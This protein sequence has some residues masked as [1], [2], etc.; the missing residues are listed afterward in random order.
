[1]FKGNCQISRRN[2]SPAEVKTFIEEGVTLCVNP[3]IKSHLENYD[4]IELT[5]PEQT[6]VV[7]LGVGDSLIVTDPLTHLT[8]ESVSVAEIISA[9]LNFSIYTVVE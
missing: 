5:I 1:M 8:G 6:S 9:E 2:L 7:E 4:G 3:S